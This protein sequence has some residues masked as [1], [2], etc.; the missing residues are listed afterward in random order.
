M[1]D[2]ISVLREGDTNSHVQ[3]AAKQTNNKQ[4]KMTLCF[5][6]FEPIGPIKFDFQRDILVHSF[7][8]I[9]MRKQEVGQFS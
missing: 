4:L 8:A 9:Q 6:K 7:H 1:C 3:W 5:F 2:I